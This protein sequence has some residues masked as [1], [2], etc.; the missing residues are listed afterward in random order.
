MN[1]GIGEIII[2]L[3]VALIVFGPSKLPELGKAAGV[4]MHEFKKALHSTGSDK[5]KDKDL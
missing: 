4:T 3:F 1:L 5:K 2:I